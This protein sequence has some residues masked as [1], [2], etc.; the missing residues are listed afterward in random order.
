MVGASA[1][2]TLNAD[3]RVVQRSQVCMSVHRLRVWCA[4]RILQ[5]HVRMLGAVHTS[6]HWRTPMVSFSARTLLPIGLLL[7][8][9]SGCAHRQDVSPPMASASPVVTGEDLDRQP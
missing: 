7:A 5:R 1:D 2:A 3:R 6:T 9:G 8:L 4:R